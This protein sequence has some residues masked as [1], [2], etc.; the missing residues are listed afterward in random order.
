MQSQS[1]KKYITIKTSKEDHNLTLDEYSRWLCLLEGVEFV[2]KRVEQ[3]KTRSK[4]NQEVDWIK[5][6]A[7]QKYIAE[8]HES[9][10]SDLHEI[11]KT[12]NQETCITLQEHSLLS[13]D[14]QTATTVN[15]K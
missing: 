6:L 14:K 4:T 7:F 5:P 15:S 1:S 2:S 3:L 12:N 8:R 11:D 10:K 13:K 9:M